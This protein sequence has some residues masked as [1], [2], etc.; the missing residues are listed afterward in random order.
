MKVMCLYAQGRHIG[1]Y[2]GGLTRSHET[3]KQEMI[4]RSI[5]IRSLKWKL[6]FLLVCVRVTVLFLCL[7]D[8][9]ISSTQPEGSY[10]PFD[11]GL[12]RDVF[13]KDS[14]GKTLIGKVKHDTDV[15]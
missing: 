6:I 13:I 4:K 14:E 1:L 2:Q 10:L 5:N 3:N 7:Q 11:E 15:T 12:K 9:G 8:P